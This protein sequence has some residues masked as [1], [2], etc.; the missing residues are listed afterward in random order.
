L[1]RLTKN[2]PVVSSDLNHQ[3]VEQ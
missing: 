2:I 1:P 3:L